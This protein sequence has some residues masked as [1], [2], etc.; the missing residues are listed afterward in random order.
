M[1]KKSQIFILAA[2]LLL[3]LAFRS[4][5]IRT[6]FFGKQVRFYGTDPYYHA[7]RVSLILEHKEIAFSV[8]PY[9]DYPQGAAVPWPPGFDLIMAGVVE[10]SKGF[11]D[12]D[13]A[14]S[15][16]VPLLGI[17]AI[18]LLFMLAMDLFNDTKIAL[19]S[20]GLL[21]VLPAH[22]GVTL[23]ARVDH[24]SISAVL[25][26]AYLLFLQRA[27][28]ATTEK[29]R[30]FY[31]LAGGAISFLA[32]F[33]I[34]AVPW[35]YLFPVL[36]GLVI[37]LAV[38]PGKAVHDLGKKTEGLKPTW[39]M[40]NPK[41]I[42]ITHSIAA[43]G[44]LVWLVFFPPQRAF[45]PSLLSFQAV[46]WCTGLAGTAFTVHI[47]AKSAVTM[48][49]ATYM[50]LVFGLGLIFH[51]P[52]LL[53]LHGGGNSAN[54]LSMLFATDPLISRLS[55]SAP[56]LSN[57][58]NAIEVYSGLLFAVFP[59]ALFEIAKKAFTG[60]AVAMNKGDQ[61][62]WSLLF[63]VTSIFLALTLVQQ[64]FTEILSPFYAL[65]TANYIV[66]KH[67][68]ISRRSRQ[69]IFTVLVLLLLLPCIKPYMDGVRGGQGP[70]SGASEL[71]ARNFAGLV[72]KNAEKPEFG[73][74]APWNLGN[75]LNY[76]C[77]LATVAN[78][79]A[80]VDIR[81]GITRAA[82]IM[83]HARDEDDSELDEIK[84]WFVEPLGIN[85][86]FY[87]SLIGENPRTYLFPGTIDK[88]TSDD[89]LLE[90]GKTGNAMTPNYYSTIWARLSNFD[91]T[92]SRFKDNIYPGLGRFRMIDEAGP[93]LRPGPGTGKLVK[94]FE[95]VPGYTLDGTTIPKSAILLKAKIILPGG[96]KFSYLRITRAGVDGK[97]SIKVPYPTWND[98]RGGYCLG[99]YKVLVQKKWIEFDIG[100][101]NVPHLYEQ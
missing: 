69:R 91:G 84:Y 25:L 24:H 81:R 26:L 61:G 94:L 28:K 71:C 15:L 75:V 74:M 68:A 51:I 77:N 35:L 22:A 42:G 83:L 14:M 92:R 55:E 13:V 62:R 96:R 98:K 29:K 89:Q 31:V 16:A 9:L 17:L 43:L 32:F 59:F 8:D 44:L 76:R 27:A 33:S 39:V 65:V 97:W 46:L 2:I 20:A 85:A 95:R 73:A 88:T 64:R 66:A 5:D 12:K 57:P 3:G 52:A 101:D 18:L 67:S 48:K 40:L 93:P 34:P 79:F 41:Q 87:A 30:W 1:S 70:S 10:L 58:M 80:T 90:Q 50:V 54:Y 23:L 100:K 78:S 19:L 56:L 63:W 60:P 72:R 49:R 6:A 47:L 45:G 36:A 7:R 99:R 38:N 21:A 82:R 11:L 53:C 86:G 4:V 37:P